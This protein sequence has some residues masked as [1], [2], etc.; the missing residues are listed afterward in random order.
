MASIFK[1]SKRKNEPYWIQYKDH[2]GKRR[3]AKGFTDKGLTE[4]LAARL[5]TEARLGKTGLI[6]PEQE[7]QAATKLCPIKEHLTAFE[8]SLSDNSPKYLRQTMN[9]VRRITKGAN[10]ESLADFDPE[11]VQRF[12]RSLRTANNF[13]HRTYNHY[14]QSIDTF[15]NWCVATKRLPS[16]PLD[17]IERLNTAV[18]VR[19]LRRAL[20]ADEVSRMIESARSSRTRIQGYSGEQRA[21]I[22]LLS[23]LTGLRKT[24]LA[25]LTASSFN[26]VAQP[27]TV[28]VEATVSKHRRK[29]VLPLHPELVALLP[30][31]LKG[32][33]PGQRLFPLLARRKAARMVKKDLERVGIPYKTQE[34]VADFHAAG[35][36][37]YITELLRNGASLPEAKELARHSDIAMTMRYT[38]IGINDQARALAAIPVPTKRPNGK[39]S[40]GE[41]KTAALHGRCI[42]GGAGGHLL[43]PVDNGAASDTRQNPSNSKGLGVN[44]HRLTPTV[45]VGTTRRLLNFF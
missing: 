34:G 25:S 39:A 30:Q 41:E 32:I 6:D 4:E 10:L 5:E 9:E 15:C 24:E 2:G 36:H 1:R 31:W 18:D 21:R 40:K 17:S 28:T 44:C 38:H 42:P 20:A 26:L 43:S 16:N 45:K 22:Y 29:D 13:G 19:R 23:Y 37:T 8:E 35:R 7:R 27:P 12:L 33:S 3:T 11:S 14:L